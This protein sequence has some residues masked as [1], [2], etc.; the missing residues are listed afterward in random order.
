MAP[1]NTKPHLKQKLLSAS[2]NAIKIC[3]TA[4]P[5]NTSFE[6]IHSLAKRGTP[7]QMSTYKLALQLFKLFNS[8]CLKIGYLSMF[9]KTSMAG[10]RNDKI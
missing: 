10:I 6:T 1:T 5:L 2:A 3:L 8:T 4:L 9:N 7:T